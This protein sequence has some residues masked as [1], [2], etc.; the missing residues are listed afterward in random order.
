[1]GTMP[2]ESLMESAVGTAQRYAPR[3]NGRIAWS[4]VVAPP[5]F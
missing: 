4:A 1:M 5:P 2:N 3:L